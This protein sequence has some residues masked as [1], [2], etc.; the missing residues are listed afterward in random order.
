MYGKNETRNDACMLLQ[1]KKGYILNIYY[2]YVR[3]KSSE[4]C[5]MF[6]IS[7]KTYSRHN[8]LNPSVFAT[9]SKQHFTLT[10]TIFESQHYKYE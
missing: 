2:K 6:N 1:T 10:V 9:M 3:E 8:G 5:L 7:F 4:N